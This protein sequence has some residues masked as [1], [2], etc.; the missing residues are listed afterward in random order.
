MFRVE[1]LGSDKCAR[2]WDGVCKVKIPLVGGQ[3]EKYLVSEIQESYR[4]ATEY[5][6]TFLAE[7]A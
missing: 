6:R 2:V 1:A 5:T 7:N 4:K 3:V